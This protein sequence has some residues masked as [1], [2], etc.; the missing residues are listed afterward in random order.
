MLPRLTRFNVVIVLLLSLLP[1]ALRR[2][3]SEFDVA[4]V[5]G[6]GWV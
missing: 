1:L 4:P 6:G 2:S 3:A 5:R